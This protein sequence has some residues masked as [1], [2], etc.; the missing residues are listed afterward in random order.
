MKLVSLFLLLTIIVFFESCNLFDSANEEKLPPATQEGKN[1]FGCLVNGKIWLPKGQA[2]PTSNLDLHYDEFFGNGALNLSAYRIDED[3]DEAIGLFSD[4]LKSVG[5]YQLDDYNRQAL[6]FDN[7]KT[8]CAYYNDPDVYR[9]GHLVITRFDL[10]NRIISGVFES[11]LYK[12]N[13]DTVKITEGRFD[14]K[15]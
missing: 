6:L 11:T 15:F 13:C 10:P 3:E 9:S 7:A 8:F 14:M 12:Q 2:G 5:S 1:T 4:S